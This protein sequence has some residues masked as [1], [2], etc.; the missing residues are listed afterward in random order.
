VRFIFNNFLGEPKTGKN[1]CFTCIIS[2]FDTIKRAKNQ[3]FGNNPQ[4]RLCHRL[5]FSM[6]LTQPGIHRPQST[7][8]NTMTKMII[9]DKK[10]HI[11]FH[12][13]TLIFF[14]SQ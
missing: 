12:A 6:G 2:T 11:T 9:N 13:E 10:Q 3:V 8:N 7:T 1:P 14:I 5:Y 4:P